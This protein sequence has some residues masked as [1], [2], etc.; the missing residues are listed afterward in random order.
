METFTLTDEEL[1]AI[2]EWLMDEIYPEVIAEQK[3]NFKANEINPVVLS[4]WEDG[5]PYGGA[6][7]GGVTYSFTPTSLGVVVKVKEAH[8]G[9]ELDLTDYDSW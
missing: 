2:D 9:K 3:R 8:T 7:G 4:H 5:Q 6:I 1:K